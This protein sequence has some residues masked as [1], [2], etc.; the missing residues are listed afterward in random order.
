M[1]PD[2]KQAG[3]KG[4]KREQGFGNDAETHAERAA[5]LLARARASSSTK[6]IINPSNPAK[7]VVVPLPALIKS[8]ANPQLGI[9]AM[10]IKEAIPIA[11]KLTRAKLNTPDRLSLLNSIVLE[12]AGISSEGDRHKILVA[13]GVRRVGSSKEVEKI[14]GKGKGALDSLSA[15]VRECV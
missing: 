12:E 13:F 14:K 11:G 3:G 9:D 2:R 15:K 8:L 4:K 1:A 6:P 5:Q 7:E 10:P